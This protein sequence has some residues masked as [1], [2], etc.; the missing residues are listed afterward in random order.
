MASRLYRT[1]DSLTDNKQRYR[2][3]SAFRSFVS[4]LRS[5]RC[6]TAIAACTTELARPPGGRPPR[7]LQASRDGPRVNSGRLP[8]A[9]L[10]HR[11][12]AWRSQQ[13]VMRGCGLVHVVLKEPARV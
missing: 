5:D 9:G 13:Q 1:V 7:S 10:S 3:N 6:G 11:Y 8:A 4:T 12:I 2:R